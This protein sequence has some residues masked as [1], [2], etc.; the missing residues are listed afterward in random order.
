MLWL[1]ASE[2]EGGAIPGDT[3]KIAFRLRMSI[4]ELSD[5]FQPLVSAGFFEVIGD[6]SGTLAELER[7]AIPEKEVTSN[8]RQETSDK[9]EG[10]RAPQAAAPPSKPKLRRSALPEGHPSEPAKAEAI[11]YWGTIARADLADWI[12]DEADQFR[13]HHAKLGSAM[14]NWDA[15]WRTWYRNTPKMRHQNGRTRESA[16]DR[17]TAAAREYIASLARESS[18]DGGGVGTPSD[19]LPSPGYG[20]DETARV[21]PYVRR[22]FG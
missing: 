8:K 15:A 21:V 18:A 6:D 5:A 22:G 17:G 3:R 7:S 11:R 14:A 10:D 19:P 20:P 13:D 4:Q 1:L 2:Y 16:H 12:D 9:G